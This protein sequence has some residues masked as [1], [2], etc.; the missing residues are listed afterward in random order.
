MKKGDRKLCSCGVILYVVDGEGGV[1]WGRVVKFFD[2]FF[3]L[4][5]FGCIRARRVYEILV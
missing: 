1:V 2:G 3:V 4:S 5:F